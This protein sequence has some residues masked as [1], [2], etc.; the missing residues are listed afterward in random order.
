MIH[1]LKKKNKKNC[2][3]KKL[4]VLTTQGFQRNDSNEKLIFF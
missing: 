3:Q 4:D 2:Q 1:A